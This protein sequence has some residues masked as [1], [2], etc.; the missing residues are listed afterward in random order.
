[1]VGVLHGFAVEF[2]DDVTLQQAAA[3]RRAIGADVAHQRAMRLFLAER[4]GHGRRDVLRD[5]SEIGAGHFSV[6][7]NLVHDGAGQVHGD[8]KADALIPFGAVSE[9]GGIDAHQFT[10]IV[11]QGAAGVAGVDGRVGLDEVFVGFDA[12]VGAPGGADNSH[13]HGFADAEGIADRQSVVADL[14]L[15]R[16][17]DHDGRQ[18]GS[19]DLEDGN[20]RLGIATDDAGFELAFVGERDLDVRGFVDDMIVGEN[21]AL[22]AD[23]HTRAQTLLALFAGHAAVAL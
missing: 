4:L 21:V 20:I 11:D 16:V 10:A 2:Q 15:G 17:A 3:L 13:G 12:Q 6:F 22:G 14:D 7:E 5:D 23:D 1:M 18:T 8:G 19:V 9:D